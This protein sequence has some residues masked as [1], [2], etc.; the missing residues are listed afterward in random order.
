MSA[1]AGRPATGIEATDRDQESEDDGLRARRAAGD[2]DVDGKDSIDAAGAGIPLAD[3]AAGGGA[4]SHGDDHARVGDGLEG[5]T[6]GGFEVARDRAGDD[7][8][9][10]VA[11]G[12]DEVDAE[13]AHV[14]HGVQQGRELPVAGVAGA[15]IEVAQMQRAAEH[16]ADLGRGA[17]QLW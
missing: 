9:V 10:G 6:D 16:P 4:G 1:R 15:G 14:V 7:D 8:A 2:V 17:G 11:R 5:A 12:G 3:D 13:A